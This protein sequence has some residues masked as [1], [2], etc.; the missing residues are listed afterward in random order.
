[1]DAIGQSDSTFGYYLKSCLCRGEDNKDYHYE[2]YSNVYEC[3]G[4]SKFAMEQ[5]AGSAFSRMEKK[6]G[7][8]CFSCGPG[9]SGILMTGISV[10]KN[11]GSA[12]ESDR[13]DH[14][15]DQKHRGWGVVEYSYSCG[16]SAGSNPITTNE[17][18]R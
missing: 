5:E 2:F 11:D 9:M 13:R 15:H 8:K 10:R 1:M 6:E 18:D 3:K 17:P 4:K 14:I 12:A 7:W 16:S